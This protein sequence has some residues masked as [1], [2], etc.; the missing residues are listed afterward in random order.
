MKNEDFMEVYS[1]CLSG[2]GIEE[3]CPNDDGLGCGNTDGIVLDEDDF[4]QEWEEDPEE[5]FEIQVEYDLDSCLTEAQMRVNALRQ[6]LKDEQTR[7][8]DEARINDLRQQLLTALKILIGESVMQT[9]PESRPENGEI[10]IDDFAEMVLMCSHLI[11]EANGLR[12]L[13]SDSPPD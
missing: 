7:G 4:F 11:L 1:K 6:Q 8:L 10:S 9:Y 12:S 3:P 2:G 13:L 5:I